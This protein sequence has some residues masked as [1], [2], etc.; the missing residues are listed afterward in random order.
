MKAVV[1]HRWAEPATGLERL[2]E[3]NDSTA[4]VVHHWAEPAASSTERPVVGQFSEVV[5]HRWSSAEP[6]A[7]SERPEVAVLRGRAADLDFRR[8]DRIDPT[9]R[10]FNV[11]LMHHVF[12]HLLNTGKLADIEAMLEDAVEMKA[13]EGSQAK[14]RAAVLELLDRERATYAGRIAK[15]EPIALTAT[16]ETRTLWRSVGA[17]ATPPAAAGAPGPSNARRQ[18][19]V[20]APFRVGE[21]LAWSSTGRVLSIAREEPAPLSHT[22]WS[23]LLA[24]TCVFL[25]GIQAGV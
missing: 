7:G 1:V 17:R 6:A 11:L 18:P 23:I 14:G 22:E 9:G 21:R 3:T 12:V 2:E 19:S 24:G 5:V 20:K 8:G 16:G 4:L 10:V 25:I 15:I 13:G